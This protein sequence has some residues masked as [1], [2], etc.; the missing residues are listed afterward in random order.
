[1]KIRLHANEDHFIFYEVSLFFETSP[2][3]SSFI[4]SFVCLP[5]VR[6]AI[7]LPFI[8]LNIVSACK[9]MYMAVCVLSVSPPVLQSL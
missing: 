7:R 1:M 6:T 9:I 8:H 4:C 3:C 5:F 2:F